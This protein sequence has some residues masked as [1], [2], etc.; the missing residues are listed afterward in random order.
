MMYQITKL[1]C[2]IV[3]LT[4]TLVHV[5]ISLLLTFKYYQCY[6]CRRSKQY[7]A[8]IQLTAIHLV[9]DLGCNTDPDPH[10][11]SH[12]LWVDNIGKQTIQEIFPQLSTIEINRETTEPGWDDNSNQ[13]QFY[14][15]EQFPYSLQHCC[16]S[17]YVS[18]QPIQ[19]T[20]TDYIFFTAVCFTAASV[21]VHNWIT[22]LF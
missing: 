12:I 19:K 14:S 20:K 2:Q 17:H 11:Y 1:V 13:S 22:L 18:K 16:S 6:Q 8:C 10:L 21:V 7:S 3:S 4:S 5:S 9:L 15:L